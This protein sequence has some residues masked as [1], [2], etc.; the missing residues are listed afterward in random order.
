[1]RFHRSLNTKYFLQSLHRLLE[2]SQR[3]FHSINKMSSATTSSLLYSSVINPLQGANAIPEDATSLSH[4]L[5]DGRGFINPW[6][7][8]RERS[9]WHIMRA[10]LWLLMP[11]TAMSKKP[12][13]LTLS[14]ASFDRQ[15]A[16]TGHHSTNRTSA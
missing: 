9:G 11:A 13:V 1:M 15:G 10:L 16:Y 3:S 7:S 5:K 6:E 2:H 4:H 12:P 14:Q 8:Y